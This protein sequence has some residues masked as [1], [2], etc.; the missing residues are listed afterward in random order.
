MPCMLKSSDALQ[1]ECKA[2][3]L[4]DDGHG[5]HMLV[6]MAHCI[7][8]SKGHQVLRSTDASELGVTAYCRTRYAYS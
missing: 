4:A 8:Q 6:M 2:D 5:K 1:P 7:G 3:H